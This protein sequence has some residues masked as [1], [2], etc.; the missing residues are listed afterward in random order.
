MIIFLIDI[1]VGVSTMPIY[2]IGVACL[3]ASRRL[4][5][6]TLIVEHYVIFLIG[7]S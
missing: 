6:H 4:V 3:S 7:H 1:V 5:T 2:F